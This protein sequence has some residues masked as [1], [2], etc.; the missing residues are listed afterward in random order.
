MN[1]HTKKQSGSLSCL[2]LN[3]KENNAPRH[4]GNEH[5]HKRVHVKEKEKPRPKKIYIFGSGF[6]PTLSIYV[7][8]KLFYELG[9][10]KKRKCEKNVE[11]TQIQHTTCWEDPLLL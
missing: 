7:R 2:E 8:P 5:P 4:L 11:K 1:P 3:K 6:R 9:E 10:Q